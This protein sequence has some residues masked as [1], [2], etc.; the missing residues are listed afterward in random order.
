[1]PARRLHQLALVPLARRVSPG[2][3]GAFREALAPVGNDARLVVSQNIAEAL[4]LGA[5]TQRVVERK[6]ERLRPLEGGPAAAA[7]KVLG[8]D[9]RGPTE[10]LDR[11]LPAALPQRRLDGLGDP[12]A[13]GGLEHDAVEHHRD[14]PVLRE[15]RGRRC[16]EV[17]DHAVHPHPS[18]AASVEARPQ[19][20]GW[21]PRGHGETEHDQRARAGVLAEK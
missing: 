16:G 10:H 18:E 2:L 5:G 8:E 4:A 3:D 14:R 12:R 13:V 21:E 11:H 9:A 7:A 15:V 20:H 6:E 1:M 19:L 17:V